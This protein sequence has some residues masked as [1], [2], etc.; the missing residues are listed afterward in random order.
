M[1]V[2]NVGYH[3][4]EMEEN[5]FTVG[6]GP[7][8]HHTKNEIKFLKGAGIGGNGKRMEALKFRIGMYLSLK[9]TLKNAFLRKNRLKM[10][11]L[12]LRFQK[13]LKIDL[14]MHF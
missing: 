13:T 11:T 14:K 6:Y 5:M 9:N 4:V 10:I 1:R 3:L 7:L 12:F 8:C 2:K